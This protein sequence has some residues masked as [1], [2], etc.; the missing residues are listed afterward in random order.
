MCGRCFD[1]WFRSSFFKYVTGTILILLVIWLLYNIG[2][3]FNPLIE[4][5][6]T[7]FFPILV[8]GIFYYVLRPLVRYLEKIR[9]SLT[10][11]ILLTYMLVLLVIVLIGLYAVPI[12]V[13]Q[14]SVLTE[15]PT[16]K[17]EAVKSKTADFMNLLNMSNESSEELKNI[18]T[19]YLYKINSMI[20][21]NILAAI[22]SITRFAILLFITP[23]ILYYLLKDGRILYAALMNVVPVRYLK[24]VKT[25]VH[26][27]D[28]ALSTFITSQ[29]LVAFTLGLLLLCG[30][31]LIGLN[32]AVILA[33]FAMVFVTIPILGSLIAI[34]P[35]LLVGLS[36][37]PFMALKVVLVMLTA[38][39]LE[40]NLIS[41]QI[42]AQRMKIHPLVVMLILLASG[43]LYGV[44]GL[45]L[46]T[47]IYAVLKVILTDLYK[48]YND[49]QSARAKATTVAK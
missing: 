17:L 8:A 35:A 5:V 38:Q 29:L 13:D 19:S 37:S 14:V 24:Q 26:D 30:Y 2:F 42:M 23:Y 1:M 12:L 31:L 28:I 3:L 41:P 46:A 18:L 27:V 22:S 11:A 49:H 40:A 4:F 45:F 7:L 33:L 15:A 48:F 6:A 25:L 20:S 32:D 39:M 44:V 9:V 47:P 36:E 21:S 10:M 43:S 16:E 34:I